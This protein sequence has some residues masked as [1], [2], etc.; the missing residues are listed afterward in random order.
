[1]GQQ[2]YGHARLVASVAATLISLAC[3][4]NYVYSAWA[5]QFAERLDL[6]STQSNLIGLSGNLGV[7]SLGVPVGVLIDRRGPRPFVLFGAALL[8]IGYFSLHQA[9]DSAS[10]SVATLCF[11]SYL[12]GLG[13]CM[14]FA[15]AVKTSALNWPHHRGT[16]TA[17]PVAAFG[18]SAF[19]FSSLGSIFF[20]GNPSAFLKLLSWGTFGLTLFGFFFLRVSSHRVHEASSR[21]GSPDP[22]FRRTLSA[23]AEAFYPRSATAPQ[24]SPEPGPTATSVPGDAREPQANIDETSSLMPPP[25]ATPENVV[26]SS[27]DIDRSRRIDFR[28][29][30]LLRTHSFWH[31]F[32]I[33]AI[34]AGTGLMTINNIGNNANALWKHFDDSVS[35]SFLVHRQQ[36]LVSALSV[37]SFVG[38][39]LSGVGSDFLVR[40]LHAS[41]LWCLFV[42]CL[43]FLV[44]QVFAL[45]VQNPH[46]LGFVS[47]F[48]GLGHGV[49]FGVFPSLVT[50][51]FGIRGLSQNWGFMMLAPVASSNVFNLLYG[52]DCY[53]TAYWITFGACCGG[54]VITLQAIRH[55]RLERAKDNDGED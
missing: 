24:C 34:L 30:R 18:L 42:A 2:L 44:A 40:S 54:L 1:M 9:Y 5:P 4:T 37:C 25:L 8:A 49:L 26:A 11:F 48:S 21:P 12:S 6:S 50:E 14:A 51:A 35:K 16:A 39:L 36:M 13:S 46:L 43:V 32:S 17:F 10:G 20:P 28:G 55:E 45:S 47:A 53:R 33:M 27:V 3:G 15:A 7:Y 19:F 22:T 52:L 23:E 29:L 38:R 31:L 41:R